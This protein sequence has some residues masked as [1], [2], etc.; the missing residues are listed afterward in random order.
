MKTSN[1][2]KVVGVRNGEGST[3]T[4]LSYSPEKDCRGKRPRRATLSPIRTSRLKSA[5]GGV[6]SATPRIKGVKFQGS[7]EKSIQFVYVMV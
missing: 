6:V 3:G 5:S 4:Q 7:I 2:G 1:A